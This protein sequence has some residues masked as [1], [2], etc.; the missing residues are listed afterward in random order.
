[1]KKLALATALALTAAPALAHPGHVFGLTAGLEHPL[2][3][4][5]HLSAM[6]AVGLWSGFVLPNR[7]WAGAAAFLSAMGLGAALGFAG[8]ALPFVEPAI[9]LSVLAFGLLLATARRGQSGT[10]TA[11][12]LAM[13]AVFAAAHGYAHAV[14]AS[15]AVVAYLAG[16]LISTLG[17][18]LVGIA[19]AS[20]VARTRAA[21]LAQALMGAGV[22]G[23]GLLLMAAG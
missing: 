20:A 4:P 14:E 8:V 17:L 13:I 7:L 16:F 6:L 21:S 11:L 12:S 19:I 3:G 22:T 23:A 5:D 15:G 1:M 2:T 18:H 10:A 9:L